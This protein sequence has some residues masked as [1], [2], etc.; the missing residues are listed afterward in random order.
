VAHS[1][2]AVAVAVYQLSIVGLTVIEVVAVTEVLVVV[3]LVVL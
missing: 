2:T 1:T 3:P